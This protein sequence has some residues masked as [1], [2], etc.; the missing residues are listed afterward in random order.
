MTFISLGQGAPSTIISGVQ[1]LAE[2]GLWPLAL[3]VFVASIT[4]TPIAKG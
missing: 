3:L 2:A 1:E 4:I